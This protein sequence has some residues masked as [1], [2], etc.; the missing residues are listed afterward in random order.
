MPVSEVP[1]RL[2]K[3]GVWWIAI[4]F[5]LIAFALGLWMTSLPNTLN[6][7]SL[8][9]VLPLAFATGPLASLLSPLL[10]G[11]M[12]DYR[13]SAQKLMGILSLVGA[14][15]LGLGFYSLHA[16]WGPWYYLTFQMLNGLFS[17]PMWALLSTVALVNLNQPDKAFPLYRLWG[18]IGWIVAGLVVSLFALD[19]SPVA[20]MIAAGATVLLGLACFMLPETLPMGERS[21]GRSML[22][23]WRSYFGLDALV[24][25]KN[26]SLRVFLITSVIFAIPLAAFY[27]YAPIHLKEIGDSRP[28]ASMTIGQ[29]T[30]IA[31]MLMLSGLMAK[32]RLRWVLIAAIGFA[33]VRYL[34][35]ALAGWT[36]SLPWLWLGI[37][38]HGPCYTFYS[39]TGQILVNRQVEAG[40]R[41]QAQAL[42]SALSIGLG[43]L[44]GTLLCGVFYEMTVGIENNWI[45]YWGSL[46]VTVLAC[47]VYF[48]TRYDRR[49]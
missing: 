23:N 38:M 16:G 9:W 18:T 41:N 44:V 35:F 15:F 24:L 26:P 19:S 2:S 42:L 39:V 8:G 48:C 17:A 21:V 36:E 29:L 43:G 40:L 34:L 20:G 12:A 3:G 22:G 14:V 28:A 47:G 5:F 7:Q 27:M 37:A 33:L 49:R 46:A 25:F 32:G 1:A 30:E 4:A 31:A 45:I 13:F 10:F 6:T 11:A